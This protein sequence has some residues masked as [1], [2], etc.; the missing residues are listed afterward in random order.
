[1]TIALATFASGQQK[2]SYTATGKLTLRASRIPT[3]TGLGTI[4]SGEAAQGLGGISNLTA[5]SS[6]LRT[7]SEMLLST[8]VVQK[9]ID[10][11]QFKDAQGKPMLAEDLIPS[12]KVKEVVGADVLSVTYSNGNAQMASA[13]VNQLMQEYVKSNIIE[14]R[15]EAI[16][17]KEFIT[18]QLPRTEAVVQQNDTELRLLKERSGISDLDSETKLLTTGLAEVEAQ[19]NRS[20]TELTKPTL[21]MSH[22]AIAW[23]CPRRPP[24]MQVP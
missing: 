14:N 11:V 4:A 3:L 24:L 18:R 13:L 17:A 1:M 2:P 20:R 12:L 21:A 6:P 23:E 16:A 10:E 22:Y 8:P 7:E 9:A 15:S 19:I 5:Q